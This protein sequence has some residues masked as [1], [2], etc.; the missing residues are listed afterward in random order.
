M[1]RVRKSIQDK[2]NE[3][4]V[5]TERLKIGKKY[6]ITGEPPVKLDKMELEVFHQVVNHLNEAGCG[7]DID[8]RLIC[9]YCKDVLMLDKLYNHMKIAIDSDYEEAAA[10]VKRLNATINGAH[11]R[12]F[13]NQQSLGI[14][15]L[16]RRK[17][18]HFQDDLSVIDDQK[19]AADPL[20][21]LLS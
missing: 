10:D 18:S 5:R 16:N 19:A 11:Q 13:Q 6:E 1:G 17:I 3:G 9:A 14:G 15:A 4:E 12:I 7:M 20:S 21:A 2:L 8:L